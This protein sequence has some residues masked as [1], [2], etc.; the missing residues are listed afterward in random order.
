MMKLE[1]KARL[2]AANLT[3]K[4]TLAF[5][6]EIKFANAEEQGRDGAGNTVWTAQRHNGFFHC[7][8]HVA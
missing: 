1:A 4:D 7:R 6:I 5:P 2:E 3:F 8:Y